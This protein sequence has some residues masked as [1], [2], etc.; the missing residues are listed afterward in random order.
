VGIV[1]A[2]VGGSLFDLPDLRERLRSWAS[3]QREPILFVP[4]GGDSADVIRRMDRLHGLGE[5]ASHWLALR[6]LTVNA[7]LLATLLGCQV[8]RDWCDAECE[9]WSV[10][11]P[12]AFCIEDDG[13]PGSLPHNWQVTSD[14]IAARVAEVVRGRLVLLKSV[15]LPTALTVP[16]A[17]KGGFVDES[18]AAVVAR[19]GL[20]VDWIN[21][22][23]HRGT[24]DD[25]TV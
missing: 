14:S 10:L 21:L 24:V 7:H 17:S 25:R 19:A 9:R 1:V 5:E 15:D 6:V 13:E 12:Y 2:K 4:G 3:S 18:F 11:D 20:H 8:I 23:I 16:A 22:R